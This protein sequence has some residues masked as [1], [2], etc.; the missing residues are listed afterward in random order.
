M[1]R[2]LSLFY[3]CLLL[4]LSKLLD[5]VPR[6][7]ER[8]VNALFGALPRLDAE[9]TARLADWLAFHVSHFSFTLVPF[10]PAW[11]AALPADA[12]TDTAHTAFVR[13]PRP[14]PRSR[15]A[16]AAYRPFPLAPPALTRHHAP[17]AG[18][19]AARQDVPPR[20]P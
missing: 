14:E 15:P 8:A 2:Q 13:R 18:A 16:R 20:V 6:L 3:T 10:A 7:I 9:L 11:A 4:D 17:S 5:P 19:P 12:A 1:P